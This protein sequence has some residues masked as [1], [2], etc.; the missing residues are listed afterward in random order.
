MQQCAPVPH[1]HGQHAKHEHQQMQV[2][3]N[4]PGTC[5]AVWSL[6]GGGV[7]SAGLVEYALLLLV[8]VSSLVTILTKVVAICYAVLSPLQSLS[9]DSQRTKRA[10]RT[11][12]FSTIWA[13]P[14]SICTVAGTPP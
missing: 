11:H 10:H 1:V 4:G 5:A 8:S 6:K 14:A 13:H 7:K 12:E 2:D 3:T 9:S